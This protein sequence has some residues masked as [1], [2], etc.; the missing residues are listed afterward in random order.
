[1]NAQLLM[2]S[3]LTAIAADVGVRYWFY[4]VTSTNHLVCLIGAGPNLLYQHF[5]WTLR[6]C[7]QRY[8][9][10]PE[11]GYDSETG[12]VGTY[13]SDIVMPYLNFSTIIQVK[14]ISGRLEIGSGPV[15]IQDEDDHL[16]R[17]KSMQ[18]DLTGAG[19]KG[20]A[21]IRYDLTKHLF[22][23]A[24]IT[25]LS[26]QATGVQTQKGYGDDIAE[27]HAKIDEK[28]SLTSINSSMAVGYAF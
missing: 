27:W 25:A 2:S 21:E 1:M 28:F 11:F 15:F 3:C 24:R 17:Q 23:L 8:P 7:D 19:V 9:S 13:K 12:K 10:H 14:R 4:Q 18:G 26:I 6:N 5:D 22:A 20:E 16:L